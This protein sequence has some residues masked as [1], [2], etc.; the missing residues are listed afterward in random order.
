[1]RPAEA[2]TELVEQDEVVVGLEVD[3]GQAVGRNG[4]LRDGEQDGVVLARI[5][6]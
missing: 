2:V 3:I 1:M 6:F 5:M 4:T